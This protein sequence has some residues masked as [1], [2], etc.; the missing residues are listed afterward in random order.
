MSLED[1]LGR[2]IPNYNLYQKDRGRADF[3]ESGIKA[4]NKE[5]DKYKSAYDVYAEKAAEW[6]K[7]ADAYNAAVD[8]YN[9]AQPN[10]PYEQFSGYVPSPGEFTLV[11]PTA[12]KEPGFTQEEV[13][14]FMN[15]AQGRAKRRGDAMSV[16]KAYMGR[17]SEGVG[18]TQPVI[19]TATDAGTNI[20]GLSITPLAQGGVVTP[21]MGIGGLLERYAEGGAVGSPFAD[22]MTTTFSQISKP[23]PLNPRGINAGQIGSFATQGYLG[24]SS[25]PLQQY[26]QYL[27]NTYVKPAEE[28]MREKVDE[29]VGLVDQAEGVHFGAEQTFG[30]GGSQSPY[31]M[32]EQNF[33]GGMGA[34]IVNMPVSLPP[35]INAA[36]GS[37]PQSQIP[38]EHISKPVRSFAE[39]GA[40]QDPIIELRQRVIATYGF[41]PAAVAME[42]GVDPE[43]F[44][45]MMYQ[46]SRGR[47]NAVSPKGAQGLMQLMPGTAEMLGVDPTD[48]EQNARGGARYLRMMLEEFGTIPLA[49]AAYNAGPGNVRKYQGVPPF[50]ETRNYIANITGAD[51]GQILPEMGNYYDMPGASGPVERPRMRPEGLGTEDYVPPEPMISEYLMQGYIPRPAE[52]RPVSIPNMSMPQTPLEQAAMQQAMEQQAMEQEMAARA[53]EQDPL[54]PPFTMSNYTVPR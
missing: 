25:A 16:A 21:D 17:P 23:A 51:V 53:Q 31:M 3:Y 52:R 19:T 24:S 7:K 18:G 44:M 12:P 41:D 9:A 32:G 34:P 13:E 36:P 40:V 10:V 15:A 33:I 47:A 4:Y 11:A 28:Q 6:Q 5:Y 42:E 54:M 22:P 1:L 20:A 37:L 49:L 2:L 8:A 29:F 26:Q 27:T 45:R 35:T 39:G 50:E 30:L 48:P 38:F 43:L 14:A 46:E